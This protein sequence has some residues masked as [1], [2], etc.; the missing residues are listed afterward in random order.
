MRAFFCIL[1]HMLNLSVAEGTH[2][3]SKNTGDQWHYKNTEVPQGKS[4]KFKMLT[5]HGKAKIGSAA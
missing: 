5:F 3:D 2:F 1:K 4:K